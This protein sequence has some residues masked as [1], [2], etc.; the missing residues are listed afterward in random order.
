MD[1][2]SWY[3]VHKAVI[4][5]YASMVGYLALAV[6][7]LLASMVDRN[8]YCYPS[9]K[10]IAEK[11]GCSRSSISRAIEALVKHDLILV[12]K[13]A[14]NHSFYHLLSIKE[15]MDKIQMSRGRNYDVAPV[16][17]NNTKL[18]RINNN[19]VVGVQKGNVRP[20][21]KEELTAHDIAKAFNDQKN[22]PKYLWYAGRYPESL[23]RQIV[24]EVMQTPSQRIKKSRA[25][26]FSY[27]VRHHAEKTV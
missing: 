7:H 10:Y 27:L 15:C 8:Q 3:W 14:S 1:S 26:L 17:P 20:R 2:G 4:Q 22:L 9:Q 24:A 13:E 18:T 19:I 16:D 21:T 11:L 25:A 12:S 5:G 23:L 6:Y